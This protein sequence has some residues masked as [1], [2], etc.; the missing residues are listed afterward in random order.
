MPEPTTISFEA[1]G[2]PMPQPRPRAF[3]TPS[4]QV[5]VYDP[6]TA[7]GWKSQIAVAAKPFVPFPPW[8]GPISIEVQFRFSRPKNHFKSN[9]DLKS[10]AP[11][12]RSGRKDLDNCLKAV[13]DAL[14]N[15]GVWKDDGQV[16][17]LNASRIYDHASPGATITVI[18]LDE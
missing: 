12:W 6:S 7:E 9:G 13:M 1:N 10:N 14:T 3:K 2:E 15:I 4:G 5:R 8:E 16:V 17:I 18:K 11:Y